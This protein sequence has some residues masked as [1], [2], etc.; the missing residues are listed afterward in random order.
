MPAP[1]ATPRPFSVSRTRV[2]YRQMLSIPQATSPT[3]TS[4][5]FASETTLVVAGATVLIGLLLLLQRSITVVDAYEQ[6]VV[7]DGDAVDAV[8]EPGVHFT[9]PLSRRNERV[10]VRTQ[11]LT[12]PIEAVET[13]DGVAVAVDVTADVTVTD[14]TAAVTEPDAYRTSAGSDVA[15]YQIAV[16]ERVDDAVSDAVE[17]RAWDELVDAETDVAAECR[18]DL[19]P[20]LDA[21]GVELAAFSVESIERDANDD[22][23]R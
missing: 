8:L 10:D 18:D 13:A 3:T 17:R 4:P 7:T 22:R 6:Y 12:R 16:T 20:D 2:A 1:S 23:G 15:D 5:L 19:A 11:T 14:P 9:S 21:L